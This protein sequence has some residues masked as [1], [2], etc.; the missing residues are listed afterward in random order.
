MVDSAWWLADFDDDELATPHESA[1]QG[2]AAYPQFTFAD[3]PNGGLRASAPDLARFG[4]AIALGGELGGTRVLSEQSVTTMLEVVAQD[5]TG[6]VARGWFDASTSL[7]EGW[8]GHDGGEDGTNTALYV[9]SER[10]LSVVLLTN[11]DVEQWDAFDDMLV[12][13]VDAAEAQ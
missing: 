13:L 12:A 5:D 11:G 2:F 1:G 6:G 9:H 8:M 3:Y 7:G 4:A 10:D